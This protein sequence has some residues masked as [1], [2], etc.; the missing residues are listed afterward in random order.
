[1]RI[2]GLCRFWGMRTFACVINPTVVSDL[3]SPKRN[4]ARGG[5]LQR[6]VSAQPFPSINTP[7]LHLD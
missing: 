1:M 4:A 2:P 3:V 6:R 5:P 7:V